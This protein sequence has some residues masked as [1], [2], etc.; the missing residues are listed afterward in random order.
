MIGP[1]DSL[2][3]AQQTIQIDQIYRERVLQGG[4]E[5]STSPRTQ[6]CLIWAASTISRQSC[7]SNNRIR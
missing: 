6:R 4:V 7:S 1:Q 2:A 3:V 5:L